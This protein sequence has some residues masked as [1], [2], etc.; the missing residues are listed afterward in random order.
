VAVDDRAG[1]I[2]AGYNEVQWSGP[3]NRDEGI[4]GTRYR[5][6]PDGPRRTAPLDQPGARR[7][8][9]GTGG[10]GLRRERAAPQ[11]ADEAAAADEAVRQ[12]NARPG[13]DRGGIRGY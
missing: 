10:V 4:G 2:P 7:I 5:A 9:R 11:P 12:E 8:P 6:R 13:R 3:G 1:G